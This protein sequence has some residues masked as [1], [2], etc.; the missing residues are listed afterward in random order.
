MTL[1]E[2]GNLIQDP[3]NI[4]GS[5]ED[6]LEEAVYPIFSKYVDAKKKG[7]LPMTKTE[8]KE[9]ILAEMREAGYTEKQ[10]QTISDIV[11]EYFA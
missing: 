9:A 4:D 5:T 6:E 11:D 8:K 2:N 10:L 7:G 1:D 3:N